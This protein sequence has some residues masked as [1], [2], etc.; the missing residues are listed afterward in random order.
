MYVSCIASMQLFA[1]ILLLVFLVRVKEKLQS[2]IYKDG[3]RI[4]T[5][6]SSI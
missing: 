4:K 6:F 5:N 2:T 1:N 3:S